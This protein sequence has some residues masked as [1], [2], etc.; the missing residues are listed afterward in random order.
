MTGDASTFRLLLY[1]PPAMGIPTIYDWV[2]PV[3]RYPILVTVVHLRGGPFWRESRIPRLKSS[4]TRAKADSPLWHFWKLWSWWSQLLGCAR[5]HCCFWELLAWPH[6]R[7]FPDVWKDS[8]N[9]IC[10]GIAKIGPSNRESE[11]ATLIVMC[12]AQVSKAHQAFRWKLGNE[13]RGCWE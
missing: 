1:H 7:H 13:G 5:R 8:G 3:L 11:I 2:P 6:F 4:L 9:A 12:K 10:I